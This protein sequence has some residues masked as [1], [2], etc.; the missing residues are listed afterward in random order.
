MVAAVV[1]TSAVAAVVGSI[2]E[3]PVWRVVSFVVVATVTVSV[4]VVVT[5]T[6]NEPTAYSAVAMV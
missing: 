3:T 6:T 2:S 1:V 5:S 4:S